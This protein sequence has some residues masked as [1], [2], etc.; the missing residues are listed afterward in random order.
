VLCT[1]LGM[2]DRLAAAP[3]QATE[4]LRGVRVSVRDVNQNKLLPIQLQV[5]R[6]QIKNL[7]N[8]SCRS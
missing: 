7:E 5:Q 2:S 1:A 6:A 8:V 4:Q 3:Q